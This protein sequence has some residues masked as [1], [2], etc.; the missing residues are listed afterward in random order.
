MK[1]IFKNSKY[2]HRSVFHDIQVDEQNKD[3]LNLESLRSGEL[4]LLATSWDP[5]LFQQDISKNLLV[6]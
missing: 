4:V 5:V 1:D 6:L 3:T 2:F